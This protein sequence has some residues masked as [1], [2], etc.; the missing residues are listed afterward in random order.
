[1]AHWPMRGCGRGA[2]A[3]KAADGSLIARFGQ[4]RSPAPDKLTR[5]APVLVLASSSVS[6]GLYGW[7]VLGILIF[8]GGRTERGESSCSQRILWFVPWRIACGRN[9]HRPG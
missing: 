6:A 2:H 1:M 8:A 3:R 5:F 7:F 4:V 9:S